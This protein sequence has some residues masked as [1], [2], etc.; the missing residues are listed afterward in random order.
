[1]ENWNKAAMLKLLWA[2]TFKTDKLWVKWIAAYCLRRHDVSTVGITNNMSWHL[3]K[4]LK[5]RELRVQLNW[6]DLLLNGK[7][8]IK[9]AYKLIQGEMQKVQ[10]RRIICNN[11]ASPK[12]KFIVWLAVQNRLPTTD[13]I[14]R[15]NVECQLQCRLCDTQNESIQHLFFECSFST[16]VWNGLLQKMGFNRTAGSFDV[17]SRIVCLKAH[18]KSLKSRVYVMMFSEAVHT[19]W[20]QR[21]SVIFENTSCSPAVLINRVIFQVA[22]NCNETERR[23]L[24]Q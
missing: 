9:K 20:C 7:F 11:R 8:S 22:C 3:K 15:W 21:N 23:L 14:S 13:R 5:L 16:E 4:I 6:E 2:I 17:E 19:I 10:W 12:S 1:M 24:V 18:S